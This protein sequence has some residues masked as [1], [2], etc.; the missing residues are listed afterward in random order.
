MKLKFTKMQ[1]CG[2]DYIYIDCF[3]RAVTHHEN[4]A[5]TLSDRHFGVGGDGVIFICPSE[6]AD[7][8][9]RMFNL[10]GSE[11]NMCGNGIRCVA[12]YMY[13]RRGF[14]GENIKIATKSG[15]KILTP[16]F[17]NSRVKSLGVNMGAPDSQ[18]KN[19][20]SLYEKDEMINAEISVNNASYR[21]T[22]LSMGNPHCVI[23]TEDVE[24]CEV[25]KIG[26]AINSS[27]LFPDGAN[28]EFVKIKDSKTIQMRVFERG[29]GETLSCGTGACAAVA[30]LEKLGRVPKSETITVELP[31]GCLFVTL[32][33][34][35]IILSGGA[36]FV[37]DG[38]V[39]FDGEN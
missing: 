29:S 20:P 25:E 8:E 4:I 39:D 24:N 15:V 22:G 9:M 37:F 16:T 12:K 33:D 35:G 1:G 23:L 38:E 11:G 34:D 10:D 3:D 17:E 7:C 27:A 30:A 28:V 2:N 32:T 36:E 19:I 14:K 26:K 6:I 21:V 5:V 18:T 31:G 13:E